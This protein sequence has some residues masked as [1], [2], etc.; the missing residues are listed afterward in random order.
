MLLPVSQSNRDC[1]IKP[2]TVRT[3]CT[4]SGQPKK[5]DPPN[6]NRG[7]GFKDYLPK[8]GPTKQSVAI[9]LTIVGVFFAGAI[10]YK[11]QKQLMMERDRRKSLGKAAIGGDFE[12][13][14]STGKTV[15]NK[16]FLGKWVL[17]YFGFSHC[18]DIC[19]EEMEKMVKVVDRVSKIKNMPEIVPLFI[20]VDPE[21]DTPQVVAK[22]VKEFS[23]KMIGLTGSMEQVQKATKAFRVYYSAGPREGQDYIVDHSIIM[24][25]INPDG[26]FV[27]YYGQSKTDE[28]IANGVVLSIAKYNALKKKRWI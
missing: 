22:Y 28:M 10:Y 20:S 19:P 2:S 6:L 15:T 4:S 14:D 9:V 24:Y 17:I 23:P 25:L 8:T 5:D 3:F 7:G 21:R 13:I 1:I 12:L 16:D 18:P 26:E 11:K 27:D